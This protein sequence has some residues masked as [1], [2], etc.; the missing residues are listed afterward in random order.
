MTFGLYWLRYF[1]TG[2][3]VPIGAT[4]VLTSPIA[5]A[6][7]AGLLVTAL[8]LIPAGTLDGGHVIY[9]L[10]GDAGQESFFHLF[11]EH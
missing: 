5:F 2:Q 6:G 4:D 3:P 8:N 10:F 1:F 7:W 9:S 11:G